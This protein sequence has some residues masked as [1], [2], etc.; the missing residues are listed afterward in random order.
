MDVQK[1]MPFLLPTHGQVFRLVSNIL[2]LDQ[3]LNSIAQQSEY[4]RW[5]LDSHLK[6]HK[7]LLDR[8]DR[9]RQEFNNTSLDALVKAVRENKEYLRQRAGLRPLIARSIVQQITLERIAKTT[10]FIT[11]KSF[12]DVLPEFEILREDAEILRDILPAD[13][14]LW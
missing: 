11:I 7:K 9:V 6:R 3:R 1:I 2:I 10:E 12:S 13:K 8:Y 5:A 14:L 4:F